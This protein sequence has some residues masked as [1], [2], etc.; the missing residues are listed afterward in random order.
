MNHGSEQRLSKLGT[1]VNSNQNRTIK[2]EMDFFS[3]IFFSNENILLKFKL[4]NGFLFG[5]KENDVNNRFYLYY[6]NTTTDEIRLHD[7]PI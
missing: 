6:A 5:W 2:Y 3:S 1:Y 7:N 4:H